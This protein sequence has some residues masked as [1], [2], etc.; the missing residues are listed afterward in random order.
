MAGKREDQPQSS[1]LG[2]AVQ[3]DPAETLEGDIGTDP[4]DAGYVPPDRPSSLLEGR[5]TGEEAASGHRLEDELAEEEPDID[6]DG[7]DLGTTEEDRAGRLSQDFDLDDPDRSGLIAH[8]AGI[9]GGA[10]SAEEAA[11]HEIDDE[12]RA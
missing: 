4:L 1:E 8:D 10:A 11:V 7:A 5:T 9:D 12:Q 6:A 2:D 3:L